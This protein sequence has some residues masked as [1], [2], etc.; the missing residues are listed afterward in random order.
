MGEVP[1]FTLVQL[2]YF[3]AAAEAR[4]MTGAAQRLL[5]SQSAVSTAVA[6]LEREL[7]VQLLIRHHARGLSLTP[8]GE[9]FLQEARGFLGHAAELAETARGLGTTAVGVIT[10]GCFTSV[11][12][13][14]LPRLLTACAA[15]H[16]GLSLEVIEGDA[17][18]L[19]SALLSGECELTIGYALDGAEGLDLEILAE[20]PPYA[21]VPP[22]HRLAAGGGPV[23]LADLAGEPMVLYDL[24]HSRDYFRSLVAWTGAEPIVRHRTTSYE[25]VRSLVAAGYG[26]SILNQ[27]PVGDR[28]YDGGRVAALALRD[29]LPALPVALARVAGTRPTRRAEAVA[30]C[31]RRVLADWPG[32]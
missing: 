25:T 16:P 15:G 8:A 9:R 5:V 2:R 22:D 26:W 1:P 14:L 23:R 20:A 21:I 19:R 32:H 7:G 29:E 11:A 12:P 28:T 18:R 3:T 27:R 4:S 6:Q 17:A 13:F 10:V 24:P 30:A 31:A